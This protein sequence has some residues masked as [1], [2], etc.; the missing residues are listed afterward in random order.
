MNKK[1]SIIIA[2]I[3]TW[4]VSNAVK[5]KKK[6]GR[7]YKV[8]VITTKD[9]LAYDVVKKIDPVYIFFPH[10]S[11]IIPKKICD[12]FKCVVFHM[13]DLPFG[14]GGSPLQNLIAR[15]MSKTRI[16]AI[17]AAESVDSGPI[18]LKRSLSLK[19]SAAGIFRNASEIVFKKM[20]PYI[21]KNNPDPVPQKGKA[22]NFRRRTPSDSDIAGFKDMNKIYDHIRMLDAEGYPRAFIETKDLRF[23][24]TGAIKRGGFIKADVVIVKKEKL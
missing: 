13:T 11:W 5:L 23:E 2:T 8:T 1:K 21:I 14:R 22:V 9:K 17:K 4:N 18:Y 19:G 7:E 10:W 16:S 6:L 3:K 24:F 20:I 12:N 15:G